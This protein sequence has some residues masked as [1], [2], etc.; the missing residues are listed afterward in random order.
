LGISVGAF[1]VAVHRLRKRSRDEVRRRISATVGQP[2][3][4]EEELRFRFRAVA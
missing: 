4:I 1:K 3:Q 2:E